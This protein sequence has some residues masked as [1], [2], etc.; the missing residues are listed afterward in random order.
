MYRIITTQ[1]GI[2]LWC[3]LRVIL[4]MLWAS[5]Q[6]TVCI[7]SVVSSWCTLQT[8][9]Y[10]WVLQVSLHSRDG[11]KQYT[12]SEFL[13]SFYLNDTHKIWTLGPPYI[14][15]R[16]AYSTAD[17]TVQC[18]VTPLWTVMRFSCCVMVWSLYGS[19]SRVMMTSP[20]QWSC[21]RLFILCSS[22]Y[23]LRR[24]KYT[25]C[26]AIRSQPSCAP[27]HQLVRVAYV[28]GALLVCCV[29]A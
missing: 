24:A 4:H 15:Q 29:V 9:I 22:R 28:V 3:V 17:N 21:S 7:Q 18:R 11:I 23:S 12:A 8:L 20:L 25:T 2:V 19:A 14:A 10:T 5:N 6:R 26:S 13:G 27:P 1:I 16:H